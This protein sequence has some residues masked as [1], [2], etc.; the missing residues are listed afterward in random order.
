MGAE[1]DIEQQEEQ[2]FILF[3]WVCGAY[4]VALLTLAT[5]GFCKQ[6]SKDDTKYKGDTIYQF[7]WLLPLLIGPGF[8]GFDTISDATLVWEMYVGENYDVML[9]SLMFITLHSVVTGIISFFQAKELRRRNAEPR[10]PPAL[11]CG[12]MQ[13][14]QVRVF[15]DVWKSFDD[16]RELFELRQLKVWETCLES[17]PQLLLQL[18]YS[19]KFQNRSHFVYLSLL[20]TCF[21]IALTLNYEDYYGARSYTAAFFF[22]IIR[23]GEIIFRSITFSSIGILISGTFM[24]LYATTTTMLSISLH[25]IWKDDLHSCLNLQEKIFMAILNVIC[26]D[27]YWD[28]FPIKLMN[29]LKIVELLL[30]LVIWMISD[31][32]I[33]GTEIW[34]GLIISMFVTFV[35]AAWGRWAVDFEAYNATREKDIRRL[36]DND[37]HPLVYFLTK[38]EKGQNTAL[39]K[40][41]IQYYVQKEWTMQQIMKLGFTKLDLAKGAYDL[42]LLIDKKR[43]RRNPAFMKKCAQTKNYKATDFRACGIKLDE[44]MELKYFHMDSLK[45]GG[46][47]IVE[48]RKHGLDVDACIDAGFTGREIKQAGYPAKEM[49]NF[50]EAE[51]REFGFTLIDM[52]AQG[53]TA[54]E[55]RK[56]GF[57][58]KEMKDARVPYSEIA[59]AGFAISD[60][61]DLDK[62]SIRAM[63]LTAKELY[64]GGFTFKKLRKLGFKAEQ[65][66]E[67][68]YKDVQRQSSSVARMS[69]MWNRLSILSPG[70]PSLSIDA[71]R[72]L[73][74][75]RMKD[76]RKAGYSVSDIIDANILPETLKKYGFS[77]SDFR[78]SNKDIKVV[79]SAGFSVKELLHSG[80]SIED[81]LYIGVPLKQLRKAGVSCD[82]LRKCGIS[83]KEMKKTRLYDCR[84]ARTRRDTNTAA[85]KSGIHCR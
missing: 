38:Q 63:G 84:H 49:D 5:V 69:R 60:F 32:T 61:K 36:I 65:V 26:V 71:E 23:F 45:E 50:E 55:L 25:I 1:S 9:L 57:T 8:S 35:G 29:G 21:S 27:L 2:S 13:F 74:Y 64:R 81:I 48:F 20:C 70:T 75:E 19:I 11:V 67:C 34:I 22:L 78:K 41:A 59:D 62:K 83:L 24:A 28:S 52:L 54:N 31:Y 68:C 72:P 43:R 40:V 56:A 4:Y 7:F 16:G 53:F 85:E 10:P 46:Y 12:I 37:C 14:L 33:V 51:L 73:N 58:I 18:F 39:I 44:I 15:Y 80:Y 6:L 82:D 42:K 77:A 30:A 17:C 76:L 3:A 47:T 66:I 79:Y